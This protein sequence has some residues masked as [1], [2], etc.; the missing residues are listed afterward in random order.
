MFTQ[1][2]IALALVAAFAVAGSGTAFAGDKQHDDMQSSNSASQSGAQ[3]DDGTAGAERGT[4][5]PADTP[6]AAGSAAAQG[7]DTADQSGSAAGQPETTQGQ[8]GVTPSGERPDHHS[9]PPDMDGP[10]SDDA[11]AGPDT[12]RTN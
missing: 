6:G 7:G 8:S 10:T 5:H 11:Q 2:R 9:R 3:H 4:T 1:T 12:T